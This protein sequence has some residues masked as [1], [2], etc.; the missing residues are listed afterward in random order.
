M[1]LSPSVLVHPRFDVT[2]IFVV[3]MPW[4]T[5]L[6]VLPLALA[7]GLKAVTTSPGA[8]WCRC[9][10]AADNPG[11]AGQLA[12]GRSVERLRHVMFKRGELLV[13]VLADRGFVLGVGA[14]AG[15]DLVDETEV[16][17]VAGNELTHDRTDDGDLFPALTNLI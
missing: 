5:R 2:G 6:M 9:S 10:S 3:S 11:L 7:I 14:G 8:I 16:F 13:V 1:F 15:M 17:R 12:L 4:R